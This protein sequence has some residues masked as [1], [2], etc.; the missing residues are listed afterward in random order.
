MLVIL[1]GDPNVGRKTLIERIQGSNCLEVDACSILNLENEETHQLRAP[2]AIDEGSLGD[3]AH[4]IFMYNTQCRETLDN[5][6]NWSSQFLGVAGTP[7]SVHTNVSIIGTHIDQGPPFEDHD[8]SLAD[9]VDLMKPHYKSVETGKVS[10]LRDTPL[11]LR[12]IL[13][14]PPNAPQATKSWTAC[15][16]CT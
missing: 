7:P 16:I 11:S 2:L 9:L 1:L 13:P 15:A 8:Q 5:L 10:T 6:S 12:S 3:V 4:I 14:T